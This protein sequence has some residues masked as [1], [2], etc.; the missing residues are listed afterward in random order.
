MQINNDAYYGQQDLF[1]K[2]HLKHVLFSLNM[3]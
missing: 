2:K 1:E 3:V